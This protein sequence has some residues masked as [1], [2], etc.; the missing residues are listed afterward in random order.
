MINGPNQ[1]AL[2]LAGERYVDGKL[3]GAAQ[4]ATTEGAA[5]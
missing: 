1:L 5:A 3:Q 2:L 4:P